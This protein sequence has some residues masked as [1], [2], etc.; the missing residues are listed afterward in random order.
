MAVF[1][2]ACG[3]QVDLG[4]AKHKASIGSSGGAS[5][6]AGASSEGSGQ[7]GPDGGVATTGSGGASPAGRGGTSQRGSGGT[8]S[9]GRGGRDPGSAG[10]SG[11]GDP[12]SAGAGGAGTAG[13]G[14]GSGTTTPSCKRISMSPGQFNPCGRT[15]GIDYSPDGKLLAVATEAPQPNLHLFD[16]RTGALVRD[17]DGVGEGLYDVEFSPD[18]KLLAVG[19]KTSGSGDPNEGMNLAKLYD[20]ATGAEV[21]ALPTSCGYVSGVGFSNDG[22]L[23]ATSGFHSPV[24]IWR[25]SDGAL[26]AGIDQQ[27]TTYDVHFAPTGS[28]IILGNMLEV[29]VY[30]VPSGKL[31]LTLSPTVVETQRPR[32]SPDGTQ[33]ATAGPDNVIQFWDATTGHLLQSVGGHT[34]YVSRILWLDQDHVVSNDWAGAINWM[35]RDASGSFVNSLQLTTGGQSLG[36]AISPDKKTL[37]VGT[38]ENSTE[39][40]EFFSIDVSKL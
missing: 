21:R 20:V 24:Q 39:G 8:S 11:G 17:M 30:D 12:G 25:V 22:K 31:M 1:V 26:V 38:G 14:G 33:I 5:S 40:F 19:G 23:L 27:S 18:G 32:F 2:G 35:T 15:T 9:A 29:T 7:G 36:L 16:V 10:A 34:P 37:A 4:D 3:S 13:F 6:A 28:A